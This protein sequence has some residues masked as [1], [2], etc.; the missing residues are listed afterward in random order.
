MD[1]AGEGG[2][3]R[4]SAAPRR[5]ERPNVL[6]VSAIAG[7]LALHAWLLLAVTLPVNPF[8]RSSYLPA[9]DSLVVE[10]PYSQLPERPG[11]GLR[12]P[13]PPPNL[14]AVAQHVR[15]SIDPTP[16]LPLSV[17]SL[18]DTL[19]LP[20]AHYRASVDLPLQ[21]IVSPAPVY[22][23]KA[24]HA[25]LSGSVEIEV[26]VGVDGVPLSA[27]IARS[28]GHR[29]LDEAALAAVLSGWRFQPRVRDG[30]AV[31]AVARVP[32]EFVLPTGSARG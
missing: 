13:D 31:E 18:L 22:P 27:R 2:G 24:L 1:A 20:P 5:G 15:V 30:E 19:R 11:C 9:G 12:L 7:A 10:I 29:A 3:L 8:E 17:P 32:I 4:A 16:T 6:R 23:R 21:A 28:S 14:T 25:G 26:V